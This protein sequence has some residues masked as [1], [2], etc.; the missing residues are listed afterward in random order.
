M[1]GGEI[2]GEIFSLGFLLIVRRVD[3]QVDRELH[4]TGPSRILHVTNQVRLDE[5]HPLSFRDRLAI[6]R[7]DS[8]I[9]RANL[10]DYIQRTISI[11]HCFPDL[12][13][14]GI[15]NRAHTP[16]PLSTLTF[17]RRIVPNFARPRPQLH[18]KTLRIVSYL[19]ATP[20]GG[21]GA[22][23][24]GR[25]RAGI[26]PHRRVRRHALHLGRAPIR[27]EDDEEIDVDIGETYPS[28]S[29]ANNPERLPDR[30]AIPTSGLR[31][32]FPPSR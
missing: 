23:V 18:R 8:A 7:N 14:K 16:R 13:R 29:P 5:V 24:C 3:S 2:F 19:T 30:Q 9:R 21:Y 26:A 25:Q 6:R 15:Q 22:G 12:Y 17:P 4:Q 11:T 31:P 1:S 28:K 20:R 27:R 10:P 32:P